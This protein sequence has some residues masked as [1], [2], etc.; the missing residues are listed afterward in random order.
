MALDDRIG[1]DN[2]DICKLQKILKSQDV[3]IHFDD[4]W[5][6]AEEQEEVNAGAEEHI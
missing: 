4:A 2:I 1:L 3:M 6:P 5:V